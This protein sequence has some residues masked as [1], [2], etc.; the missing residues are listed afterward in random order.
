MAGRLKMSTGL[1]E[2]AADKWT[3]FSLKRAINL[4]SP[5]IS[6]LPV[7]YSASVGGVQKLQLYVFGIHNGKI[8]I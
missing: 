8:R 5:D 2:N 7:S 4:L 3:K 6:P 1:Q